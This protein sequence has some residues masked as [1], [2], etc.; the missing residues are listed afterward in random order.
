MA[1]ERPEWM[2]YS[3]VHHSGDLV[4]D[5]PTTLTAEPSELKPATSR[6]S[7]AGMWPLIGS[8]II[9][10]LRI[11]YSILICSSLGTSLPVYGQ[12]EHLPG[13]SSRSSK[14]VLQSSFP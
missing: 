5:Q 13:D 1:K 9:V 8:E 2:K 6:P 14:L 3:T 4:Q 10:H 12:S 7:V 11:I